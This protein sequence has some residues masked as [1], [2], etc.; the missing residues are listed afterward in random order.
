MASYCRLDFTILIVL[1]FSIAAE[2]VLKEASGETLA[3]PNSKQ[4]PFD[5]PAKQPPAKEFSRTLNR[6]KYVKVILYNR[7]YEQP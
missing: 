7:K 3:K 6:K 5:A 2:R 4:T 1:F